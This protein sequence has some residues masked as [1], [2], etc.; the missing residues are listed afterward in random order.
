MEIKIL[1]IRLQ[2]GTWPLKGFADIEV[3]GITVRDIRIIKDVG[4]REHIANPQASWKDKVSRS[5]KYKTLITF[6]DEM[7]GELDRLVLNAY[8]RELEQR[9]GSTTV[10]E[11]MV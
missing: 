6:P 7:K 4:K 9:D 10:S 11:P 1:Q 8:H 2:N 5:I 3:N